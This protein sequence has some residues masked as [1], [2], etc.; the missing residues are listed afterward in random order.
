MVVPMTNVRILGPRADV[1]RV[2]AELHALGLVEIADARRSETVD[3]LAGAEDRSARGAELRRLI[4]RVDGCLAHATA[5][6]AAAALEQP[7]DAA[8]TQAELEPLS[9]R[10]GALRRELDALRDESL[11][12][13][14]YLEPL[15]RLLP[16]VPEL[17]DLD[18][19]QLRRLRLGTVALVLNT[20]DERIVDALRS[21]L[22]EELGA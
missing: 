7:L 17:A 11:V 19:E 12:L 16:L 22:T 1:E 3:P 8:A 5:P 13:P 21:E 18:D 20:D 15:R 2:V 6:P 4:Q 9:C 14:G 10:A